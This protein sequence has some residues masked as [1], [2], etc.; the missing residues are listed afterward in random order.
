MNNKRSTTT[1]LNGGVP[2]G[3]L[4][5]SKDFLMYINDLN[6]PAHICKYVDDSTIYEI[7]QGQAESGIQQSADIAADWTRLNDMIINGD[8]SKE[9]ITCF[10]T[11]TTIVNNLAPISINNCA[12]QRIE[13]A[14]IL[15]VTIYI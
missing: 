15:G 4:S 1:L 10:S 6:T 3:T 9:M 7:V 13:H 11:D 12:V 2:Q 14:K 8:K 5:G